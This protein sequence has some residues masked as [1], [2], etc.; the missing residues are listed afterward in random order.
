MAGDTTLN[1]HQ[2]PGSAGKL[3]AR[4]GQLAHGRTGYAYGR[5][6]WMIWV[7]SPVST[8]AWV[9]AYRGEG[10][11]LRDIHR[12]LY[13]RS[14][15]WLRL[16]IFDCLSLWGARHG[17]PTAAFSTLGAVITDTAPISGFD[18]MNAAN[19]NRVA[20]VSS[21]IKFAGGADV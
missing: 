18:N 21:S 1:E 7:D 14:S 19:T 4:H 9:H 10:H 15:G 8:Y 6:G 13:R 17:R 3:K 16:S 5:E 11:K 20:I 2:G 12:G